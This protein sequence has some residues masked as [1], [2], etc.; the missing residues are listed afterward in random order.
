MSKQILVWDLGATKCKA[1]IVRAQ[2]DG[3]SLKCEKSCTIGLDSV[4]SL[5]TLMRSVEQRLGVTHSHVDGITIG[6]AGIYDGSVLKL[7]RGYPFPMP[8]ADIASANN[9]APFAVVHDYVPLVCASFYPDL[10]TMKIHERNPERY[11]RRV[12]LGIGT[13]LGLKDGILK[14][15]GDFWLGMNEMGHIGLCSTHA[16]PAH[17]RSIHREMCLSGATFEDILSGQGMLHLHHALSGLSSLDP[18][19]LGA[20]VRAGEAQETLGAFA[21]YVGLFVGTVQLCFMPSGGI[22]MAGGVLLKHSELFSCEE[23]YQGLWALPAYR[24]ERERFSVQLITD[25][26]AALI[27]AAHFAMKRLL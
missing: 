1:G 8:I 2:N 25:D 26:N 17:L 14:P 19:E 20:L 12:A 16:V 15:N 24:T 22:F 5:A 13:G 6:A 7:E 10:E 9:W 3:D 18:E 27:G 23:F 4:D 21:F 11:G